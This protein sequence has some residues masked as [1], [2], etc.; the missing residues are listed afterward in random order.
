L[1]TALGRTFLRTS[2][3]A[4]QNISYPRSITRAV[5]SAPA[6]RPC[7]A[8]AQTSSGRASL[9]ART[10]SAMKM[11]PRCRS[12]RRPRSWLRGSRSPSPSLCWPRRP[13][14]GSL[15]QSTLSF[16]PADS[17]SSRIKTAKMRRPAGGAVVSTTP[18]RFAPQPQPRCAPW[19]V[20]EQI[21][22]HSGAA[23][24]T[25]PTGQAAG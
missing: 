24:D 2:K 6:T 15:P 10:R 1:R 23:R 9:S 20:I 21:Q 19:H 13:A 5:N 12:G 17:L 4:G 7:P 22:H 14:N 3:A 8:N 16:T 25:A 11:P 18:V